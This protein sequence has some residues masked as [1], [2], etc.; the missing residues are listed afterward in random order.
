MQEFFCSVQELSGNEDP[1]ET[2]LPACF[3]TTSY[4]S[5]TQMTEALAAAGVQ[6]PAPMIAA[7]SKD[8]AEKSENII[9]V[10]SVDG[11]LL[12]KRSV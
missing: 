11:E 10:F 5:L 3:F 12:E 8:F 4:V 6:L 7:I 2:D 1:E 9:R